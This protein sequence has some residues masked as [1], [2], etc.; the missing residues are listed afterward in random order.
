M[1][2]T[3]RRRLFSVLRITLGIAALAYVVSQLSWSSSVTLKGGETCTLIAERSDAL[4]VESAGRQQT[5]P[6]DAFEPAADAAGRPQIEYGIRDV[7]QNLD[8]AMAGVGL[9]LFAPCPILLA[10]RL[11]WL[12]TAQHIPIRLW[13]A[14]KI[15]YA[16]NFMNFVLPG[17]TGGDLVKGYYAAKHTHR[18]HEAFAIVMFDRVLGMVCL[19]LLGGLMVLVGWRDP[20]V[21]GFGRMVGGVLLVLLAVGLLY[22]S[23]RVRRWLRYDRWIFRIPLGAHIARLDRA[24]FYYRDH[25]MILLKCVV[26]TLFLQGVSVVSVFF[27]G[28]ALDMVGDRPVEALVPYLLYVPLGWII[29]AVPLTPQGIGIMEGA[30]IHFFVHAAK[31][32]DSESQAFFLAMIGRLFQMIWALPGFWIAFTGEYRVTSEKVGAAGPS[33]G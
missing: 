12:L 26:L 21:T 3:T 18:K 1:Q 22:F 25:P 32:A 11:K 24:A 33:A 6:F 29:A 14:I 7:L 19:I 17:M 31:L 4:V 30:Y 28:W 13:D 15:T 5:L 8:W 20:A 23:G 10:L 9:A 2:A 27:G 16:G